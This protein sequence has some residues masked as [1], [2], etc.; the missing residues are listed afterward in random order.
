MQI[1]IDLYQ[2]D[3]EVKID[4]PEELQKF[5][6]NELAKLLKKLLDDGYRINSLSGNLIYDYEKD[7][8]I[9]CG[10]AGVPM[11]DRDTFNTA[12]IVYNNNGKMM[13]IFTDKL[14]AL[15][16]TMYQIAIFFSN[17]RT[18][19]PISV[20]QVNQNYLELIY[21]DDSQKLNELYKK[22]FLHTYKDGIARATLFDKKTGKAA[23]RPNYGYGVPFGAFIKSR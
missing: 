19:K 6:T 23:E 21:N 12:N 4:A 16:C 13:V 1:L 5:N 18:V 10:K 2:G 15:F 8:V 7:E 17:W 22:S 11:S 14:Y 20:Y 9:D 3:D